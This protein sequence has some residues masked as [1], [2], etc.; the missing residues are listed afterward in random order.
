M[1]TESPGDPNVTREMSVAVR[2]SDAL[3][4]DPHFDLEAFLAQTL[5]E[6]GRE[7]A[8]QARGRWPATS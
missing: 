3:I 4:R 6:K 1:T 5:A 7:M 2:V 8:Q